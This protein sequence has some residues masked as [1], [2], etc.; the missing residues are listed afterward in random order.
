[1][2][3]EQLRYIIEIYKFKSITRAAKE[4]F[5]AQPNLS[6]SV[7]S[8]EDE[9]G[10]KIFLRSNHGVI[11]TEFG[12]AFIKKAEDVV[13][14]FDE[15]KNMSSIYTN[16]SFVISTFSNSIISRSFI[17]FSN[18]IFSKNIY[19]DMINRY[20]INSII[21]DVISSK[22]DIGFICFSS[23]SYN[24]MM[25]IFKKN[26]LIFKELLNDP[27]YAYFSNENS[28]FFKCDNI[29]IKDLLSISMISLYDKNDVFLQNYIPYKLYSD[30]NIIYSKDLYT[31]L[32]YLKN[33][34][35]YL[36]GI[37][38]LY[39]GEFFSENLIRCK[40]SDL[41]ESMICGY[42]I[43]ENNNNSIANEFINFLNTNL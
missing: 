40:I 23:L 11:V 26:N 33:T 21:T 2:K 18:K 9:L 7:K 28:N 43:K 6:H 12:E 29:C 20:G 15:L 5:V 19:L 22:A 39:K 17:E 41:D 35:S 38:H 30:S 16:T 27:V 10:Q 24:Y 31:T 25:S 37:E 3:I 14:K 4:L 8:L 42:L 13:N 34:P 1:M 36:I 32:E